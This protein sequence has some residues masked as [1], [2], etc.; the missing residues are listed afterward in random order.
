MCLPLKRKGDSGD[1]PHQHFSKEDLK[2][3]LL[4]YPYEY[5]ELADKILEDW[6]DACKD[7]NI[8]HFVFMGTCLGFHRDKGYIESDSDID[9]G[10]LCGPD[11]LEELLLALNEK[12]IGGGGRLA[13]S[14]NVGRNS[15]L[16]DIWHKFGPLHQAYLKKFDTIT[17]EGRTYNTPFPLEGYLE[18]TYVDWKTPTAYNTKAADGSWLGKAKPSVCKYQQKGGPILL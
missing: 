9:V 6:D 2:L 18:F 4:K 14:I 10:V 3:H 12:G 11:I 5:K 13:C 15:V 1:D 7:L 17:Y 8:P 16:L